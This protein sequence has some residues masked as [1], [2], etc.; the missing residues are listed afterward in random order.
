MLSLDRTQSETNFMCRMK[1]ITI[2]LITAFTT[3][4]L[5]LVSNVCF[6]FPAFFPHFPTSRLP[7]AI[8]FNLQTFFSIMRLSVSRETYDQQHGTTR[9]TY[10]NKKKV[11]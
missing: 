5:Y 1:L 2:V 3:T 8:R 6:F 9:S 10:G 7:F 4:K 11:K